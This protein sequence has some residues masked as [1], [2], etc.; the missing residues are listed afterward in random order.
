MHQFN[1]SERGETLKK[2]EISN[3]GIDKE[4]QE[5]TELASLICQTPFA[6]ITLTDS[7]RHWI[8]SS[9]IDNKF[10]EDLY[11]NLFYKHA[12][13]NPDSILEVPNAIEDERFRNA[14]LVIR[15]PSIKFC[16][17]VPLINAKRE[18]LGTLCLMDIKPRKLEAEQLKGLKILGRNIVKQIELYKDLVF[19]KRENSITYQRLREIT[20]QSPDYILTLDRDLNI[21]YMN[22]FDLVNPTDLLYKNVANFIDPEYKDEYLDTCNTCFKK[23]K[24]IEKE[25]LISSGNYRKFYSVKFCPLKNKEGKADSLLLIARNISL[26]RENRDE[27]IKQQKILFEAQK[28]SQTGSCEWDLLSGEAKF[29]DELYNILGIEKIDGLNHIQNL[30]ARIHPDDLKQAEEVTV[31]AIK[32]LS[33]SIFKYRIITPAGKLKYIDGRGCPLVVK[34]NRVISILITVQDITQSVN[35]DRELF[36]AVVQSE[37][38][39]RARMAGE[40]HDGVCQYLA[41][42]KLMIKTIE[43]TLNSN[44]ELDMDNIAGMVKYSETSINEA[45]ELTRQISHNLLPVEFHEKGV[46]QSVKEMT[47]RLNEV[48]KIHYEFTNLGKDTEL[49][50]NVSINIFRIVQEFIRNSQKY[51]GATQVD[52]FIEI[53]KEQVTLEIKDNGVG[54]DLK[55]VEMKKGVGLLS[56]RKRIQSIGGTFTYETAPGKGVYL[57]LKMI[58]E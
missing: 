26:E 45:L 30:T 50:P 34:D 47:E 9:C 24:I 51:S 14:T 12:L 40:L 19:Q 3:S 44:V 58:A 36:T 17:S 2:Y 43:K 21:T 28:V 16:V 56:M 32:S 52:I 55:S 49:D 46:I 57:K 13:Q 15:E 48:D 23:L 37:E 39:E 7:E 42:T 53:N 20:S 25:F 27:L 35:F 5:I 29:S 8:K 41:G 33:L 54:F 31:E 1:E 4:L 6:L 10:P 11:E 22:R 18:I 38:K